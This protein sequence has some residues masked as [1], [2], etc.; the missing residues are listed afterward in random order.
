MIVNKLE[1]EEEKVNKNRLLG[2]EKNKE[3]SKAKNISKITGDPKD[4][5][6]QIENLGDED[7]N[8]LM[9]YEEELSRKG[10]YEVIFPKASNI[11]YY[12]KFFE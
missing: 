5:K 8:I 2:F 3:A 7:L 11:K 9:Q 1:R 6:K 10:F 12:E 4:F